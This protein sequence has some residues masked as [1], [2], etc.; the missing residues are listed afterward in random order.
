M[1]KKKDARKRTTKEW[2]EGDMDV[3]TPVYLVSRGKSKKKTHPTSGHITDDKKAQEVYRGVAGYAAGEILKE[4][5]KK[6]K[7]SKGTVGKRHKRK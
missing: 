2:W 7:K 4:N 5:K 3:G 6:P 1:A